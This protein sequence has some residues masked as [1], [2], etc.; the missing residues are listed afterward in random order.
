VDDAARKLAQS[1]LEEVG[2]RWAHTIGVVKRAEDLA[3]IVPVADRE[4][5]L[6]AA[7]LHDIGY[8]PAVRM[9]G[10]H[11]LDGA[12][13]LE[14]Q[15]WPDRLCGLV[16][17][18]SGAAFAAEELGLREALARFEF[19]ESTV[20][21]ALTYADQTT[22]PAGQPVTVAERMSE[23]LARHGISSIQAR[24]HHLREPYL[25]AVAARVTRRVLS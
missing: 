20:S 5:L 24:V 4:L 11:P 1:L 9:S 19:E 10:F 12:M 25:L 13:Y 8:A 2:Q 17:Y 7:W 21:D 15:G 18:H 16:A 23:M 3:G 22:G 14:S 6:S